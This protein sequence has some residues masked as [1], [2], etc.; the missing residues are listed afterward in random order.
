[1]IPLAGMSARAV[2]IISDVIDAE[3]FSARRVPHAG[4]E[5]TVDIVDKQL[6]ETLVVT[7]ELSA[8]VPSGLEPDEAIARTVAL[9]AAGALT[10]AEAPVQRKETREAIRTAKAQIRAEGS[11]PEARRQ[12]LESLLAAGERLRITGLRD[13]GYAAALIDVAG[14]DLYARLARE[15]SVGGARRTPSVQS[16]GEALAQSGYSVPVHTTLDPTE[17][18]GELAEPAVWSVD[19]GQLVPSAYFADAPGD[20]LTVYFHGATDRSRFTMPRYERL[21]TMPTLGLGPVM[22]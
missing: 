19:C 1:R 10:E 4:K 21:R 7:P 18:P 20:V 2:T 13:H 8:I 17:V 12:G 15:P 11:T 16:C 5:F 3:R 22:F 14:G 9:A 6:D